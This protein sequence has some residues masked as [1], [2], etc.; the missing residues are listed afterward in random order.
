MRLTAY[1]N[2]ADFLRDVRAY[3]EEQEVVNGLPL[4]LAIRLVKEPLAYGSPPYFAAVAENG[5]PVLTALMTPPHN[6]ILYSDRKAVETEAL[7]LLARDLLAHGWPV[8]GVNGPAPLPQAFADVWT[9]QFGARSIPGMSQRV[10]QLREVIPTR[11][12]PGH[13]RLAAAEDATLVVAWFDA[14]QQESIPD[15]PRVDSAQMVVKR[16][17]E[18]TIFLW[19]DHGPVSM[20]GK[21]RPTQHG[22]SVGPVYTPPALRRR[23]YATSCVAELSQKLLDSGFECVTLF[24]NLANPTSNAIYRQIGYCPVCDFQEIRFV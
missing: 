13:L 10:Y 20:A 15:A 12:A 3:L 2:A 21:T 24:T 7:G 5:Q 22:I 19:D 23:G 9:A 14:F 1:L 16:I 8:A 17:A 18:E 6:L 11:P 4:G